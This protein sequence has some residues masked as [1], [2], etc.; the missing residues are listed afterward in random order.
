VTRRADTASSRAVWGQGKFRRH[1]VSELLL[2]LVRNEEPKLLTGS[3]Q[4]V[5]GQ[6]CSS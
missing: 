1:N 5:G 3:N 2:N 4:K 6:L